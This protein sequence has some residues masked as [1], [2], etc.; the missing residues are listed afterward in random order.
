MAKATTCKL[1]ECGRKRFQAF[2][3][4]L[5]H[6]REQ[7]R[8]RKRKKEER[9]RTT[10]KYEESQRKGLKKKL[11]IVF[12]KLIRSK[13]RCE[14]CGRRPP[15]VVLNCS[16][17]FSRANLSVR[18]DELNA[19]CLCAGDHF[20]WHQSPLEGMEWLKTIRTPEQLEELKRRANSIKQWTVGELKEL[21][22]SLE[23]KLLDSR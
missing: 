3:L 21:L 19:K 15:E 5:F 13:G 4:C 18:W 20:E 16:H 11:D 22:A 8:E 17:I 10:K 1:P 23:K 7:A 9:F 12:S 6:I 14:R 2:R